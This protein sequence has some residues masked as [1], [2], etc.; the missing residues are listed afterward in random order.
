MYDFSASVLLGRSRDDVVSPGATFT[1]LPS[2]GP[3][4]ISSSDLVGIG[5]AASI[6][7]RSVLHGRAPDR[8]GGLRLYGRSR[9]IAN[10]PWVHRREITVTASSLRTHSFRR[11]YDGLLCGREFRSSGGVIATH[12]ASAA[13]CCGGRPSRI[14]AQRDCRART[15]T[16]GRLP[17]CRTMARTRPDP[18]PAARRPAWKPDRCWCRLDQT[19]RVDASIPLAHCARSP[20]LVPKTSSHPDVV[21]DGLDFLST[22]ISAGPAHCCTSIRHVTVMVVRDQRFHGPRPAMTTL[23]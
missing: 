8:R 2:P 17:R 12:H 21:P 3:A 19:P 11:E 18:L 22:V 10:E 7:R 14:S 20:N 4:T 23:S 9:Y 13:G 6:C 15:Q 16:S 1:E 5:R